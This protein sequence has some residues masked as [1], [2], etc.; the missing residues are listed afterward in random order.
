[1]QDWITD[2]H[3]AF[4]KRI[5]VATELY[6]E[7]FDTCASCEQMPWISFFF[8]GT[9][10]NRDI[11]EA[12]DKQSNVAR[13]WRG[14]A[15]DNILIRRLYFPGM[16]TPLDASNP[17]WVGQIRDSEAM[18][19]GIGFGG[20]IRLQR[21]ERAL[22]DNLSQN[23]R[24]TRIDIA[25]FGFSRGA[26]LARAFVNRLLAKCERIDGVPHWPCSTALDG[27][28]APLH[29]RFLGLFD[30]VESI[31]L[32]A[33][34][35]SSMLMDVP[36]DVE[37]CLHLVAGH[38]IRAAFPL[39]RLGK[40]SD[41]HR[42]FVY[43]GV[44]SD[45][46]GG[47]RPD[48][49]ARSDALARIALNRMRLEAAM[50]GVP[51]TAPALLDGK[52]SKLFEYDEELKKGFDEY[53]SAVQIGATLEENY[54]AHMGLYYGWLKARYQT[55][56]GDVYKGVCGADAEC[57]ADLIRIRDSFG[58]INAQT[59]QLNWQS[60]MMR[61]ARTDP[62]EWHERARTGGVPPK[63]TDE[64][65]V[66][67][68][69]WINP[70]AVSQGILRFFDHYVHDSRAGF[71]SWIGKGLYLTPREI[72]SPSGAPPIVVAQESVAPIDASTKYTPQMKA[73]TTYTTHLH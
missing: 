18:G 4:Q 46:G 12:K 1:M 68:E 8:D 31:G 70:P 67:Y 30:T 62:R 63:L 9:G 39:T 32:P 58:T 33:H 5:K 71:P 27:K 3:D 72:I 25:V 65:R 44:H 43:P 56:P 61:L 37:R 48:E 35:L 13:L 2:T 59:D 49:Q 26:A 21:A 47:Y 66:Y 15:G 36:D 23:N 24:I 45:V 19:G 10:N 20:D 54:A 38:E 6:A 7:E 11:D 34:N 53:M 69:T 29:I 40:T 41:S 73:A 55:N 22:H 17:T 60:Y 57:E 42:E 14:H 51:F 52:T 28:S 64:E 16:G 50:Y